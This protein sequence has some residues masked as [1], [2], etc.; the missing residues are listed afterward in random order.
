[1]SGWEH[2]QHGLDKDNASE[3]QASKFGD[4]HPSKVC[5]ITNR[6]DVINE[7]ALKTPK[8]SAESALQQRV[9]STHISRNISKLHSRSNSRSPTLPAR[10]KPKS[11][12]NPSK[13][14]KSHR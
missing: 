10:S 11:Y 4:V 14:P 12:M 6:N 8:E 3:V 2:E 1:M 13:P 5:L 9:R 7:A